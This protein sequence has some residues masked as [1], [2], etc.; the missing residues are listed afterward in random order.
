ME[1]FVEA[2]YSSETKTVMVRDPKNMETW[3][4]LERLEKMSGDFSAEDCGPQKCTTTTYE[5]CQG[6]KIGP[7]PAYE[8]IGINC[9]KVTETICVPA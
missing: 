3:I 1:K 8:Q 6:Y 4:P 2:M 7:P 9:R 5:V